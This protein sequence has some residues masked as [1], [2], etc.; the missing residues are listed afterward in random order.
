MKTVYAEKVGARAII[1]TDE[2]QDHDDYFIG[3]IDDMDSQEVNIP[4]AYLIGKNGAMIRKTLEKLDRN[5]A[6]I[7]LPVNLTFTP[8]HKISQ[9]PWLQWS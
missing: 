3:M 1:I 7:N 2:H 4:S 8:I 5:Y 9:P 6:I